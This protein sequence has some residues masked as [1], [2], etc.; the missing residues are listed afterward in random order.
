MSAGL[1]HFSCSWSR[2]WGRD[3]FLSLPGLLIIP[4]RVAEAKYALVLVRLMILSIASTARHG[5]IPNLIS[6]MGAAPR[7]NSRDST[8]FFLYGIKQY[9][10]LTSDSNILSEKVYR[11]FRTD[12]SDADLVQDEDTVPLNVIIQEIMQRHYSGIDFIERDAGEKID[13][14]MKEEGFHITCGVDP[15]T[16]FLFGG[17]RW[18]CGTWMDKMGSS[19]KAK[20]KGFPATPR[21]GSCVELVGLFSAISKWLEELSTKSQYPY[22]GVKGTDETVVTWGSLN[23]KIQQNFEKYFWI[24]QDRNE[25]MKKFPK[26]VSVLN[27][28][29]IYKD[30]V[31]SSLVYTDYQF[32]P[33]VLVSMVVVSSYFN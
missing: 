23:V 4:G 6:S 29:G 9:V 18:N 2:V 13:S 22:R 25:A 24:P 12:D 32:R 3:I 10:Q 21:D 11:V 7:Y 14:S 30:T 17:S 15:D 26:D 1:P 28:T 27:R 31:N 8:W 33:N 20:N 16:G 5:L 19:E